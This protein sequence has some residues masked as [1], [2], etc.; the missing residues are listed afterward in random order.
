LFK[1]SL[2]HYDQGPRVLS[3]P[4][5]EGS[6]P[7]TVDRGE[8][9]ATSV[10]SAETAVS[11]ASDGPRGIVRWPRP[12]L[13]R[14]RVGGSSICPRVSRVRVPGVSGEVTAA[15]ALR[16]NKSSR[17]LPR[18]FGVS[19]RRHRRARGGGAPAVEL[20]FQEVFAGG[21][22][23]GEGGEFV[24]LLFGGQSGSSGSRASLE[25]G[26]DSIFPRRLRSSPASL[27]PRSWG[28]GACPRPMDLRRCPHL[29][30][31]ECLLR[32]LSKPGGDG[33]PFDLGMVDLASGGR[34]RRRLSAPSG[35][36]VWRS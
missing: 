4:P 30:Y 1:K 29:V 9:K 27:A 25:S 22:S 10:P 28:L 8:K 26:A 17:A 19:L 16:G 7:A 35:S 18:P 2:V 15:A 24:G 11:S 21:S 34:R 31:G 36:C 5:L 20:L 6:R 3:R 12:L 13:S 33:A 14:R 23:S 32:F